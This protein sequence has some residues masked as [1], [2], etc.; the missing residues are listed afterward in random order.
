MESV[1]KY[2]KGIKITFKS[3]TIHFRDNINYKL[4][5]A[6]KLYGFGYMNLIESEKEK[7]SAPEI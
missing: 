3:D 5:E 1:I 7:N 4:E 2:Q 6:P